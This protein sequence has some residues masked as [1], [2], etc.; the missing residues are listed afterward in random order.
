ML[1]IFVLESSARINVSL[2]VIDVIRVDV[3]QLHI[4]SISLKVIPVF[5]TL[6]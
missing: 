6:T 2:G 1:M 5:E 3:D 4:P